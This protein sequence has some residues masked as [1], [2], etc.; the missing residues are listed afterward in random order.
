MTPAE[1]TAV[2]RRPRNALPVSLEARCASCQ[3]RLGMHNAVYGQCHA[4][5]PHGRCDCM[6]FQPT[7][8][9]EETP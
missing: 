5:G 3:H 7:T 8:E 9:A 1:L 4:R 6:D 2:E